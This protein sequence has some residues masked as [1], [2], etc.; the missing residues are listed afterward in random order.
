MFFDEFAGGLLHR[1][2]DK[3]KE[4]RARAALLGIRQGK[5]ETARSYAARFMRTLD[6]IS[7]YDEAEVRDLFLFGL[8]LEVAKWIFN[9]IPRSLEEMILKAEEIDMLRKHYAVGTSR[10]LGQQDQTGLDQ[11]VQELDNHDEVEDMQ[12]Q[13]V[14]GSSHRRIRGGRRG[15]MQKEKRKRQH[16][17]DH[18]SEQFA[19]QNTVQEQTS[20]SQNL[21]ASEDGVH[22]GGRG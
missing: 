21:Q 5:K 12:D 22:S 6:K 14:S 17:H 9:N 11:P 15:R 3:L 7:S 4:K 20:P 8:Q 18:P 13:V 1:F 2:E 16:Q 19:T 10:T